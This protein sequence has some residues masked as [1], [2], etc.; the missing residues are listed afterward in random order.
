MRPHLL[1]PLRLA[2]VMCRWTSIDAHPSS[3]ASP[4]QQSHHSVTK[5]LVSWYS[6]GATAPLHGMLIKCTTLC[7]AML[8][9]NRLLL[10]PMPS[11]LLTADCCCLQCFGGIS[12]SGQP[13]P[14]GPKSS[15]L[16]AG[17]I[18]HLEG[19]IVRDSETPG[20]PLG[21]VH[22]QRLSKAWVDVCFRVGEGAGVERKEGACRKQHT[23][24][25]PGLGKRCGALLV[26]TY[27][28]PPS[29]SVT[30]SSAARTETQMLCAATS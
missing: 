24:A 3:W 21:C 17:V 14:A 26:V 7:N 22:R 19:G 30:L 15:I 13:L 16:T 6:L 8:V 23:T 9:A 10:S 2:T 28:E 5:K 1:Q 4:P 11:T 27:C 20:G 12:S 29:Y 18:H 25:V